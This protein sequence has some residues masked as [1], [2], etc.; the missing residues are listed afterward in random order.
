M[1]KP[2]AKS[3]RRAP[4][5]RRAQET[6]GSIL[7]AAARVFVEYGY[8]GGTTNR[9][10]E[11]A[12]VSVGSLYE[13]FHN[14]TAILEALLERR[15]AE[16]DLELDLAL[17]GGG[18]RGTAAE[19]VARV[20]DAVVARYRTAPELDRVLLEEVPHDAEVRARVA[21]AEALLA[22]RIE[23]EVLGLAGVQTSRAGPAALLTARTL[24][25]LCRAWVFHGLPGL[26]ETGFKRELTRMLGGYL[27]LRRG[28]APQLGV[29]GGPAW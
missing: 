11:E 10:A 17:R 25:A 22:R 29:G 5:Q 23:L 24:D 19:A 7:D 12:G 14:K 9:I 27:G 3:A 6:L 26:D 18:A 8:A 13:Y 2:S 15:L 28:T 4:V 1:S 16:A 20:V 21:A